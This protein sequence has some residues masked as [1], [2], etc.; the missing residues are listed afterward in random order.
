[1]INLYIIY[2]F[3]TAAVYGIGTYI[4][5]L[6]ETLKS[7]G[8]NVCVIY[9]RSERKDMWIDES[10]GIRY[11]YIPASITMNNYTKNEEHFK[12]YYR[13]ILYLLQ[14]CIDKNDILIF[15]MNHM[16]CKP[17]ADLLN[18]SFKCKTVLVVHYLDSI[19][20]LSGN[21][22]RL[23]KIKSQFDDLTDKV[24]KLVKS[25]SMKEKDFLQSHS[26]DKI[27]CLSNHCFDL[28]HH[29]Y[30]IDKEKIVVIK[31]GL[32][33]SQQTTDKYLLRRKYNIP[34]IPIILFVGRIDDV[35]GLT[36]ALRAFR[37]VL[38]TFPR[39]HFIIAGDGNFKV[40]MKECED[41]WMSVTWT[42]LISKDKLY[43]LY[44]IADIGIM[45]SFHEQ[46]SYVAIE[47]MMHGIPLIA[48]TSTGLK[49][50]VEDRVT[51]LHIPV[52]E[53]QVKVEI[54]TALL[55][56]KMLYLLEHP[57]ERNRMSMN[58]RHRYESVYSTDIF[59]Q[60]M[61]DFYQSLISHG[62]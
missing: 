23:S 16:H 9:L 30:Q 35:K 6:T 59:R 20:A 54:D 41:I 36:Y 8:V 31:N 40:F 62:C 34:D 32:T 25:S 19:M 51:G 24:E 21:I 10:D 47:M 33:D 60:N 45:P 7:S 15:Q 26:I 1:M 42:G 57:E 2:E 49:E 44:S 52:I 12:R 46:C 17:L 50:M 56:E 48:S 28:L 3:S 13:N 53:H 55:A 39:C 29:D 58:A 5:E 38:D 61:L 18:T 22:S 14:L 43:D 4:Q 11:W 37:M 27:I